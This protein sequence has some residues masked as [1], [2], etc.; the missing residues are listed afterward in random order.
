MYEK[1]LNR[2]T[3]VDLFKDIEKEEL[4]RIL[5]CLKPSIKKYRKKDIITIEKEHLAG[6][7]IVLE[8]EVNVGKETL[9]GDRVMLSVLKKGELFGEVAAFNNKEWLATTV[10]NTDCTILFLP[11]QKIVGVCN[12]TCD[13]HRRL[14]QNMLQIIAQKAINLNEKVEILSLKSIRQKISIYLLKQYSIKNSLAFNVPLKRNELAE[15]LLVSRPSLSRELAKMKEEGIIDFYRNS[16]K[17]LNIES[18]KNCL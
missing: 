9:A 15:Y 13:G 7:G 1:W 5:G 8:G 10:A 17:I 14:I 16:F 2:L 6:I 18:L 11:P 3:E 12:K 4:K